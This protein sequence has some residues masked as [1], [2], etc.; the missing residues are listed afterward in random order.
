MAQGHSTVD[1]SV[2]E[3]PVAR[4]FSAID[5]TSRFQKT[6]INYCEV[7]TYSTTT[8]SLDA[9]MDLAGRLP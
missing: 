1:I 6:A 3:R 8:E 9:S 5:A 4:E 7:M 2:T